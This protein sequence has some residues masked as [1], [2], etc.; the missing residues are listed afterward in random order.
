MRPTRPLLRIACAAWLGLALA[1]ASTGGR[2][3]PPV[4]MPLPEALARLG[5]VHP[6]PGASPSPEVVILKDRHAVGAGIFYVDEE[7]RAFQRDQHTVVAHLVAR[8]FSLLGCEHTLGPIPR[9]AAAEDH[10]AVIARAQAE[11]DDL[12][13]WSVYQPL[14]YEAEFA[15]RLAVVGVEDPGLYQEDLDTLESIEKLRNVR[16]FGGSGAPSA[17]A[18]DA[19]ERRLLQKI[20][21]N[22]AARGAA[23]A[24]NLLAIMKERGVEK[25]I[26]MLGASHVP[27]AS[28]ELFRVSVAQYVFEAPTFQRKSE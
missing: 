9:N 14:R 18:L 4:T 24:R 2:R 28:A 21:A 16:R 22:V 10:L 23:A 15:G 3:A 5:T 12:N 8:G 19:E 17:K 1:C 25:A 6:V 13:R 20:R 7:L 11:G 27:A 26:L